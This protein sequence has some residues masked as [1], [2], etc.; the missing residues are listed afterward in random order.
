MRPAPM[1]AMEFPMNMKR[2][3]LGFLAKGM[4]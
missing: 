2:E 1:A 4:R 3:V